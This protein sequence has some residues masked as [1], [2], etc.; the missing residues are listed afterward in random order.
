MVK[1]PSINHKHHRFLKEIVFGVA[2]ENVVPD[3]EEDRVL[4]PREVSK[5]LCIVPGR[6][7]KSWWKHM[8]LKM[9]QVLFFNSWA[10]SWQQKNP[11]PAAEE[12]MCWE[13]AGT[14][15]W[16]ANRYGHTGDAK[17]EGS[18]W[19]R[20]GR[21]SPQNKC[22]SPRSARQ[23]ARKP[24]CMCKKSNSESTPPSQINQMQGL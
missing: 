21:A 18:R 1:W 4:S 9:G 15:P 6:W 12:I 10:S 14:G 2:G 3:L 13:L 8:I 20:K 23:C 11:V 22:P 19:Q 5:W 16:R 7:S 17:A 24:S